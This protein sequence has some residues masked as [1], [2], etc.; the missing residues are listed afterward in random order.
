MIAKAVKGKG[1]R[2]A[3][4]YDLSKEQGHVI[5]TN[6][7]GCTARALAFEFGEIRKLRPKLGK[8]VLHV[9]LSAAPGEHLTDGQW[10]D[11]ARRYIDGMGLEQNQYIVTRHTDTEHE[12]IHLLANRIRFDGS[13]TSDS[14]DYRRQEVLMRGIERDLQLQQVRPSIEALRHA[15]SKGEIE[16]GVRTGIPSTRQQLQLLC[17]G[18]VKGC[19]SFSAYAER[20]EAA[21]VDLLPMTQLDGAK[22]SGLSYRLDGVVMKGSDLGKGYS[23]LGL[24]KRGVDYEKDRDLAAAGRCADRYQAGHAGAEDRE[25]T[26][27]EDRQRRGTGVD[28]GTV[29]TGDGR[30]DGRHARDTGADRIAEQGARGSLPAAD[31]DS[32]GG[33]DERRAAGAGSGREFEQSRTADGVAALP[34]GVNNGFGVSVAR[35]RILAL[36]GAAGRDGGE[37]AGREG[38][39]GKPAARDLSAEAIA[40]QIGALGAR[41]YDIVI[42]E[43]RSGETKRRSWSKGE[44]LH[45]VPWL[46]RMNAKG[47]DVFIAPTGDQ[48]LVMLDGLNSSELAVLHNKGYL[49]AATVESCPGRFDVW[50]KLSER[51]IS[52]EVRAVAKR[53]L[54]QC[55]GRDPYCGPPATHGRLAGLTN[56]DEQP[57]RDGSTPYVLLR[58]SGGAVA[59]AAREYLERV[60]ALLAGKRVREQQASM[61]RTWAAR[62]GKS[63]GR[64]L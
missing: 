29:G 17:D 45:S 26:P 21:G 3:L 4:E 60:D 34:S 15:P 40:R 35:D 18:A 6:M 33:M 50:I 31:C 7:S 52:E 49:P 36:A 56:Q 20:L 13:V 11:I 39:G 57:H 32:G 9:S 48:G 1:F 10:S 58:A 42:R 38:C 12:H 5:D 8:A 53:G 64:S 51:G 19:D 25:P 61:G 43:P 62:R 41:H 55:V 2:G 30:T 27:S 63:R 59:T 47:N 37:Q 44:L 28:I 24:A 46:K 23:P 16:E 14:H 22:L 54:V